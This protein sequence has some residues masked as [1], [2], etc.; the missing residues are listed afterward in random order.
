MTGA[1]KRKSDKAGTDDAALEQ[2]DEG[3]W[4]SVTETIKPLP[5]KKVRAPEP[6]ASVK[7]PPPRAKPAPVRAKHVERR[8]TPALPALEPGRAAGL[9]RRTA[10]RLR[11]GQ[12]PIDGR[13]DLHG[14]TQDEAYRALNGF[15]ES[16]HAAKQRC[17]L[18]ITGKGGRAKTDDP[19]GRVRPA[20]GILRSAVP[21]W[22]NQ[23]PLRPLI[24]GFAGAQPKDG[25]GGALYV[26][27]KRKR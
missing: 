25:G 19:Y 8:I 11:K 1:G 27:I 6:P 13:L 22:L 17:V 18:V 7:P 16:A 15:I 23:P 5:G 2:E 3:L 9:D 4:R 26:L 21:N 20:P 24:L 12:L 14:W 10:E